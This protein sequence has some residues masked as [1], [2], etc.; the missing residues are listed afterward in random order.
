MMRINLLPPEILERRKAEKRIGWVVVAAI[1][2]ALLL[3]GVWGAAFMS[4]QGRR[5]DLAAVQQQVQATQAQANQLAIFEERA[6]ELEGRRGIVTLA[7]GDKINW[8]KLLD[9]LSLVLPSDVWVDRMA[10]DQISGLQIQ[11]YAVDAPTDT[12]DAGH[13]SIA[14]T[15][16]RLADLEQLYNVWLTNSVKELYEEQDAIQFTITTGVLVPAAEGETP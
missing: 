2:V 14:K 9:E 15:L 5:D 4:V 1:A 12:P 3:A 16:V 7:L 6:V 8:A 10:F 13:K 11:G